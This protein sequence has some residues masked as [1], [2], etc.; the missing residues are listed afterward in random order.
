[1]RKFLIALKSLLM[2]ACAAALFGII[3]WQLRRLDPVIPYDLPTWL[4]IPGA[5]LMVVGAALAVASFWT[6]ASAGAL[7]LHAR[8]PDPQGLVT[9]GPFRYAR[10]PMTKGGWTV[11]CGWGLYQLSPSILLF[12]AAMAVFLH[13]FVVFVEEPKLERRF[14]DSYRNYKGRV[15]RWVPAWRSLYRMQGE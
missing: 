2:A 10:N 15:N 14:G 7:S 12:A 9:W 6:F 3:T 13:L 11:L 1:M 4:A 5:L 8:F